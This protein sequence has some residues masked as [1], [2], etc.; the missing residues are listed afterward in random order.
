M[1]CRSF[2][3]YSTLTVN[4]GGCVFQVPASRHFLSVAYN[5]G[6]FVGEKE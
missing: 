1:L 3:K 6:G 2:E 4:G 5:L